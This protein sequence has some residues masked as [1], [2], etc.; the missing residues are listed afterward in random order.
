M[1]DSYSKF[2]GIAKNEVIQYKNSDSFFKLYKQKLGRTNVYPEIDRVAV[3]DRSG[4][5]I[6]RLDRSTRLL[7]SP[8]TQLDLTNDRPTR[9][10]RSTFQS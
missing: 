10:T 8:S 4:R 1:S 7:A 3:I 5:V 6:D 2:R 9:S